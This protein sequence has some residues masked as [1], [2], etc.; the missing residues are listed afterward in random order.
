MSDVRRLH[1]PVSTKVALSAYPRG[2][3]LAGL[4]FL[5]IHGLA[6]NSFMWDGVAIELERMGH[7]VIPIDLRGHGRSDK[8]D[9]GYDFASLVED[10]RAVIDEMDIDPPI[11]VGQSWGGNLAMELAVRRPDRVRAVVGVDGGTI[12][13]SV[14]Y[15]EWDQ[16][17][18]AL[19]PPDLVGLPLAQ[20]ESWVRG[21]HPDWPETGIRGV[22]GNFEVFPDGTVAPWLSREHHMTILRHL[23][24]HHPARL[25]PR[26]QAPVLLQVAEPADD[27]TERTSAR[28]RSIELAVDTLPRARAEWFRPADHDLHAQFPERCARSLA[29]FAANLTG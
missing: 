25:Y 12:E 19:A 5:L 11:V 18:T 22:L 20:V 24:E 21:A 2:L 14:A 15:P 3:D 23:W 13:L 17:A 8:P 29:D 6:S 4:P 28:R 9:D 7:P 1:V 27:D 26:V 10:L 16:A